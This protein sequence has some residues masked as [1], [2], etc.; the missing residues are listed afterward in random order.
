MK[1]GA[2]VCLF[3]VAALVLSFA[4]SGSESAGSQ[5][6][7]DGYHMDQPK[8]S[9]FEQEL[10]SNQKAFLDAMKRG[11]SAYV[12]NAI[13]NDFVVIGANGESAGKGDLL[14]NATPHKENQKAP[15]F[16]D[17]KVI[18]LAD[19]AGVVTYDVVRP[20]HI[21]RYQHLSDTWVKENGQWKLKFQQ[22][23]LNLWSAHDL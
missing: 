12:S 4:Q 7:I 14:E 13:A 10:L 21:E 19:N 22:T 5:S 18:Q 11:D 16:Y 17:F 1:V 9:A 15:L 20:A 2:V 6:A 8:L 23:T 3:C